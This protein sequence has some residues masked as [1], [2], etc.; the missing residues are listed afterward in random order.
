MNRGRVNPRTRV[1]GA[2][3]LCL[4]RLRDFVRR[5]ARLFNLAG[6]HRE[7]RPS[8]AATRFYPKVNAP[9]LIAFQFAGNSF[10][11]LKTKLRGIPVDAGVRVND[12][13]FM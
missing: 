5:V 9:N 10:S 12:A 6:L 1:A 3:T 13:M 8:T 11:R 2:H 7:R 4:A